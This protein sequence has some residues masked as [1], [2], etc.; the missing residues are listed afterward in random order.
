MCLVVITCAL[1]WGVTHVE[2]YHYWALLTLSR[3]N[4]FQYMECLRRRHSL[5]VALRR[6]PDCGFDIIFV[7][8]VLKFL[9]LIYVCIKSDVIALETM[10]I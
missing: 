10:V 2:D 4:Y 6:K 7:K 9:I 3:E 5:E 8:Y 1:R